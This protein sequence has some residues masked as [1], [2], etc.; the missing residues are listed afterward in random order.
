M[1]VWLLRQIMGLLLE[2]TLAAMAILYGRQGTAREDSHAGRVRL[3]LTIVG[4]REDE[5]RRRGRS[6]DTFSNTPQEKPVDC[7]EAVTRHDDQ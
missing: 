6:C 2:D 7:R 4:G 5:H 1:H 3:F